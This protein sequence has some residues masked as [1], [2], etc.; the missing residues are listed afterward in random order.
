[1]LEGNSTD[2][3]WEEIQ[4]INL[5]YNN[6]M[7]VK[8]LKQ[9]GRGKAN[10]VRIGFNNATGDLFTILDADLTVS[11]IHLEKFYYAYL[12]GLGD[13]INGNRLVYPM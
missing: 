3:T 12:N 13:F 5:Q 8:I 9:T 11:S 10:A 6:I 1:L 7:N 2:S 4:K